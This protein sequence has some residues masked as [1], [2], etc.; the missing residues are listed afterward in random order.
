MAIRVVIVPLLER[1]KVVP[2]STIRAGAQQH[3]LAPVLETIMNRMGDERNTFLMIQPSDIANDRFKNFLKPK[4][5]PQRFLVLIF[6]VQRFNAI[7][8]RYVPIGFR[9]P[10]IIVDSI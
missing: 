10:N 1:P 8:A 9:V 5:L 6:A 4:S 7:L 3:E 2:D